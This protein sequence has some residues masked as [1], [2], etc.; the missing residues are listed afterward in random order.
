MLATEDGVLLGH[1]RLDEGVADAGP[2]RLTAELG[3]ELRD[4]LGG[5]EVVDDRR[6]RVLRQVALGDHAA[7]GRRADGVALLVDDEAAVGVPVE[8]DADVRTL[9]DRELLQVDDVLRVQRVGLVV[10]EG[11]VELEEEVVEGQ[12]G[13]GAE[14]GG[15]GEATHSVAGVHGDGQRTDA[16]ERHQGLEVVRVVGEDVAGAHG[17]GLAVE[18]R[19]TV[20]EH[21]DDLGQTGVLT[22][23]AGAGTAHLDAVVLR[24]VVGRREH[25]TGAVQGPGGV[26]ELVGR[27]QPQLDGVEALGGDAGGEG[28]GE[29][30]GAGTHVMA[31]DHGRRTLAT[32][33][34]AEGCSGVTDEVGVDTLTD[35]AADVVGLDDAAQRLSGSGGRGW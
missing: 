25:R 14:H 20:D 3:D 8:G 10:G 32:H 5:D 24:R 27:G 16:V 12:R 28:G 34:V 1:L 35:H 26:V 15:R 2:D 31:D 19:D 29:V 13:L 33:E 9:L 30:R 6:A 23:R 18:G 17:A 11:P 4:R 22:D 21:V 7:D